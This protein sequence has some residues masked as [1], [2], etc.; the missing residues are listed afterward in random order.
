MPVKAESEHEAMATAM[1][2]SKHLTPEF[3]DIDGKGI[4]D[5]GSLLEALELASRLVK[6]VK[7]KG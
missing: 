7:G 3:K 6:R 1:V 2:V 5:L 4:A